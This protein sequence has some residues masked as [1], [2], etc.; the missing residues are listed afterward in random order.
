MKG[1]EGRERKQKG[2]GKC[3]DRKGWEKQGKEEKGIRQKPGKGGK[4]Q[5]KEEKEMERKEEKQGKEEKVERGR[6]KNIRK[7]RER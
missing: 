4:T 6:G 2:E 5:G 1:K 3:G 7:G